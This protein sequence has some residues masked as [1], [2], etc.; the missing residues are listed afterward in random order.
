MQKWIG[1]FIFLLGCGS[2]LDKNPRQ[3]DAP[4]ANNIGAETTDGSPSTSAQKADDG[5]DVV[6]EEVVVSVGTTGFAGRACLDNADCGGGLVCLSESGISGGYC[7]LKCIA[8]SH[9]GEGAHCVGAA[10]SPNNEGLCM[11]LCTAD[12]DCRGTGFACYDSDADGRKECW[13]SADGDL[14]IG[15]P[16]D[17]DQA[18]SGG[19]HGYCLVE[20]E[21]KWADGYCTKECTTNADCG[22][23][24]HC[25]VSGA[26]YANY[27]DRPDYVL[28]DTDD[29]GIAECV[30]GATGQAS[31]GATCA[32]VNDCAGGRWGLCIPETSGGLA[33]GGYCTLG[34]GAGQGECTT[35]STCLEL[36]EGEFA[37]VAT[38][39]ANG[40]CEGGRACLTVTTDGQKACL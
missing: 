18:C 31:I 2:G 10:Q 37:C 40:T 6:E 4:N 38:C 11:P 35:G 19:I 9:C 21:F 22:T 39:G 32:D 12:A 30:A 15:S 34:C 1:C 8:D 33:K 26:C 13:L 14:A 3:V 28:D 7:T 27:C 5:P 36:G 29:D 20:T 24:A 23:G 16:C 17:A 25:G